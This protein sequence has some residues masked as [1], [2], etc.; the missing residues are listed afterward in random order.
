MN[1]VQ[2][3]VS[4][5]VV[6]PFFA[7]SVIAI[8]VNDTIGIGGKFAAG[9]VDTVVHLDLQISPANLKNN[10]MILMLLSETWEKMI[11]EKPEAKIS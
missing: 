1:Q 11:H 3:Q 2:V 5:L 9:V 7:T 4:S 8:V 10:E 6:F